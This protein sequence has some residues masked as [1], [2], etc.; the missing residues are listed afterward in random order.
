MKVW[1]GDSYFNKKKMRR[2]VKLNLGK[3]HTIRFGHG[4]IVK[5]KLIQATRC[6]FNFL[7]E[8]T[9]RCVLNKHL[10]KSKCEN[11]LSEDWFFVSTYFTI[12]EI[13]TAKHE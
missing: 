11:H 12:R 10:Y 13:K 8:E 3:D 9:N 5:G 1:M 4:N 6:G 7:N 2:P